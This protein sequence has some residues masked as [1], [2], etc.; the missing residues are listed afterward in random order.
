M[1][2]RYLLT[3]LFLF[4]ALALAPLSADASGH[5]VEGFVC[6]VLNEMVG[7]HNPNSFEIGDGHYSL[8]PSGDPKTIYVPEHATNGDGTGTPPGPHSEPGDSDY[9]AIWAK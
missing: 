9:T 4:G 6:P 3:G 7:E 1:K 5:K 8:I 2:K